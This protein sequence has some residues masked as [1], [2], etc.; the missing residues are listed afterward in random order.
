[1]LSIKERARAKANGIGLNHAVD[2]NSGEG[3]A[4]VSHIA[5]Q[6]VFHAYT[7]NDFRKIPGLPSW[8]HVME[9]FVK[10]HPSSVRN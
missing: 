6:V 7:M 1:M 8:F 2:S 4:L 9:T 3:G 10:P 5:K